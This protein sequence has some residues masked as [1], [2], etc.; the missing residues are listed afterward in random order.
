MSDIY[1]LAYFPYLKRPNMTHITY[2][3]YV[4]MYVLEPG[5]SVQVDSATA[6]PIGLKIG[7]VFEADAEVSFDV[8]KLKTFLCWVTCHVCAYRDRNCT[9]KDGHVKMHPY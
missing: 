7:V 8:S 6:D 9:I 3:A 5:E 2:T 4:N 1:P